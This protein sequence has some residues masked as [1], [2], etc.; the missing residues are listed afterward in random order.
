M[1]SIQHRKVWWVPS[2]RNAP[3]PEFNGMGARTEN[4]SG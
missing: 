1:A 4:F 2:Q 3:M